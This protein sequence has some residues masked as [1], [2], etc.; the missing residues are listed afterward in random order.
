[1]LRNGPMVRPYCCQ[2]GVH[3]GLIQIWDC[4][5]GKPGG[6]TG[7]TWRRV[8][9]SLEGR[10]ELV[11]IR[12]HRHPTVVFDGDWALQ[13]PKVQN[14][15]GTYVQIFLGITSLG[16]HTCLFWRGINSFWSIFTSTIIH[17]V[18]T[19]LQL[20]CLGLWQ[21]HSKSVSYGQYVRLKGFGTPCLQSHLWGSGRFLWTA[22]IAF[23]S[24]ANQNLLSVYRWI[25]KNIWREV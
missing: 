7:L 21:L 4:T 20:R 22:V 13:S 10:G 8:E 25:L 18:L 6:Q 2:T 14:P 9:G 19:S 23:C 11:S 16:F 5:G 1:M 12:Y 24:K 15:R 17:F 3:L